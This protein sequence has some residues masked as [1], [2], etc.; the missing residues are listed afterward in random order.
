M[1]D[2]RPSPRLVSSARIALDEP[3]SVL[4]RLCDHLSEY[5]TVERREGG[6]TFVA[7]YGSARANI[8]A[9]AVVVGL[10]STDETGLSFLKLTVAEHLLAFAGD[11]KPVIRWS[12]DGKVGELLA[13]FREMRVVSVGNVTPLMR[14]IVL[15]GNDLARFA[16]GGLH[17]RLLF[18]PAGIVP[19]RWP[20]NGEDGRPQWP[21]GDEK[22]EAR[23]YTIR[24]LDVTKGEVTID[25]LLHGDDDDDDHHSPGADFARNARPG[26]IV[27]MT[28]PGGGSIG[29]AG[30]YIL[31]GDETALPAIARLL[32][33]MPES[34]RVSVF[35]EVANADEEQVLPSPAVVDLHWLH[36]DAAGDSLA[37]TLRNHSWLTDGGETPFILAG[38]EHTLAQEIRQFVLKEAGI[39]REKCSIAAYWRRGSEGE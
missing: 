14:R 1:T 36:R 38:C 21:K 13:Y 24:H 27:G 34:A 10:E 28:G 32:E 9:G 25:M 15:S 29:E 20:V 22:P 30:R 7:E 16:K 37:A 2:T 33:T 31:L 6:A 18:P 39:A 19:P 4:D 12:G 5:V 23:I 26:D 3:A 17:V 8:E 35:I 11:Q